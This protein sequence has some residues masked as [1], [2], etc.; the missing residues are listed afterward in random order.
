[1]TKCK[2][3][4]RRYIRAMKTTFDFNFDFYKL[5][6]SMNT[7]KHIEVKRSCHLKNLSFLLLLSFYNSNKA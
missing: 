4:G 7:H 5:L 2:H 1:M 3:S 6:F